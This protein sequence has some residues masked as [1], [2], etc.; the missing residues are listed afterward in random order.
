MYK[1]HYNN[2]MVYDNDY[3]PVDNDVVSCSNS[4]AI[5]R[6]LEKVKQMDRGY[7]KIWRIM[8]KKNGE[9][10]RTKVE[11]Y[12]TS[13]FGN[14]IRDAETGEYYPYLVGT[15]D[16]DLFFSV[17]LATGE[18]KSRNGSSTL[19]YLSPERYMQHQNQPLDE[20]IIL[21]WKQKKE[22]RMNEKNMEKTQTLSNFVLVK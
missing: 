19:F 9:L 21:R 14:Q 17:I 22:S 3:Y 7:N 15:A 5:K 2:K 10:K 11:V 4:E 6:E 12:T 16:E 8:P 20:K 1:I 18:C 13:G